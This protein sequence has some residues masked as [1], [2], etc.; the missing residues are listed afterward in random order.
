MAS[1]YW[2]GGGRPKWYTSVRFRIFTLTLCVFLLFCVAFTNYLFVI[3]GNYWIQQRQAEA[4]R[5]CNFLTTEIT[6]KER[7]KGNEV[8]FLRGELSGVNRMY[9]YIRM[10]VLNDKGRIIMDS[11][12]SKVGQYIINDETLQALSGE[13]ATKTDQEGYRIAMPYYTSGSEKISGV[14][15]AYVNLEPLRQSIH[16]GQNRIILLEVSLAILAVIL[17]YVIAAR[18]TLPF[19]KIIRWLKQFK[20]S[21]PEETR[22]EFRLNDEY[23]QIVD[24]VQDATSDMQRLDRSRKEFVSNVSHELKTPLSSIKVLS[25]SLLLQDNVPEEMYKEFLSDISGE[26]DR[27]NSIVSDLLTLVRLEE[28]VNAL[29]VTTFE[30]NDLVEDILKRLK[31]LAEEKKIRLIQKGTEKVEMEGDE[32]KLTLAITNLVHNA[33]KYN[34]E[35]GSV[36]V[37]VGKEG[38]YARIDVADTGIGI[39]EKHFDKLFERFYRVDKARDRGAGGTGLGL[40]IVRQIILLHHGDIKVE[41]TVGEGTVFHVLIPMDQGQDTEDEE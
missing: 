7:D 2:N 41:S 19:G 5:Y 21:D 36:T 4:M 30:A 15:Y 40:S 8:A 16:A 33:I 37:L 23:Q 28:G 6:V 31:P 25:E 20:S 9:G 1:I 29:T 14:I 38:P 35:G 22:P 39:E 3:W 11:S 17:Y 32:T 26:V 24:S 18:V 10:L 13:T 12:E 34:V 27:M